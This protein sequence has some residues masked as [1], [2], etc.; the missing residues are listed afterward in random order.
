[1]INIFSPAQRENY[2][3]EALWKRA[4]TMDISDCLTQAPA[5]PDPVPSAAS[6]DDWLNE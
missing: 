3:L 5:E 6:L 4:E 2:N 1:M